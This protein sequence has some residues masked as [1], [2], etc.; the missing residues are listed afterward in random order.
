MMNKHYRWMMT[1]TAA[2]GQTW[3]VQ[4]NVELD[5]FTTCLTLIMPTVFNALTEGKAE[6]GKPGIGCNGP[7]AIKT[8][9]ISEKQ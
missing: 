1:G 8:F 7:Y 2:Q 5:N 4:G 6:Y 3:T 9:T